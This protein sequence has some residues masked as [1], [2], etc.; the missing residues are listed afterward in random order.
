MNQDLEGRVEAALARIDAQVEGSRSAR[1]SLEARIDDIRRVRVSVRSARGE[2]EVTASADGAVLEIAFAR[3]IE[4][5]AGFESLLVRT[6]AQA[7]E[8]AREEA[9]LIAAPVL[10]ESSPF[11]VQLHTTHENRGAR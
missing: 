6:I 1:A 9:A 3:E 4:L 5:S 2:C 8:K 11:V 7:Q 10:G